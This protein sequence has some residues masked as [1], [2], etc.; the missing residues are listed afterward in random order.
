MQCF[1]KEGLSFKEISRRLE[2]DPS[3]IS[4]EV[5]KYSSEI[6][7]AIQVILI[8]HAEIEEHVREEGSI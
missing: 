8:I 3:T 6:Q 5:R 7:Q 2:K 4:R 1:L